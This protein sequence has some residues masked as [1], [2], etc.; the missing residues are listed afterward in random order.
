MKKCLPNNQTL[1]FPSRI[2]TAI[3]FRSLTRPTV[4]PWGVG[5][6]AFSWGPLKAVLHM[7]THTILQAP[8]T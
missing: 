1:A 6:P 5:C 4:M 2:L 7:P 3:D 8:D